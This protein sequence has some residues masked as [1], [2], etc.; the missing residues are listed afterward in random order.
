MVGTVKVLIVDDDVNYADTTVDLLNEK[1]FDCIGVHSGQEAMD[2]VRE[3]AFDVILLDVRMP[4]MNGVETYRE[5]KKISPQTAIIFVTAYRMDELAKDALKEGAYGLV[6]KPVDINRMVSMIERS[7]QGGL[8]VMVVDD[9]PNTCEA[10]KGN[11]EE[12][13][14]VVTTA[15]NGDEAIE[16]AQERPNDVVFI[17]AKLPP[18]NGLVVYMDM[19]KINPDVVAVMM[20]DYRDEMKDVV[21]K[22][23]EEGAFACL[24]KPFGVNEVMVIL[25]GVISRMKGGK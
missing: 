10:L 4:V 15:L 1:G 18:L 3:M 12:R 19:K 25:E 9:N 20:T 17:D 11:L 7:R 6:Y 22:A 8:L 23:L 16:I 5:L 14:Y 21:E 24:Y 13:G 2:K